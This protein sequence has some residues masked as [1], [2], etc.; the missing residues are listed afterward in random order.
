ME[1]LASSPGVIRIGNR[2]ESK[3][4]SLFYNHEDIERI[5]GVSRTT[6]FKIIN[7]LRKELLGQGMPEKMAKP[8]RIPKEYF[9]RRY[10]SVIEAALEQNTGKSFLAN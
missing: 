6:A 4:G 10:T 1:A 9:E 8:G 3:V 5:M 2:H 7:A